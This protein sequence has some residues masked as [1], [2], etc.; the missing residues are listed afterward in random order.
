MI[1]SMRGKS[2]IR[3]AISVLSRWSLS[4]QTVIIRDLFECA[5]PKIGP[6]GTGEGF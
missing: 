3:A 2:S 6:D 1:L 4:L 5:F